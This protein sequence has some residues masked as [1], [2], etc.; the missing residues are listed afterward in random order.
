MFLRIV[1]AAGGG[2]EKEDQQ[3]AAAGKAEAVCKM[4]EGE[5]LF[6]LSDEGGSRC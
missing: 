3:A 5:A 2:G 1:K 6:G 4:R